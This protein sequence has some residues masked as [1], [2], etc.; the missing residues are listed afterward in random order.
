MVKR[1][2]IVW[3]TPYFLICVA[4][5]MTNMGY[6]RKEIEESLHQ[7][8]YDDI[9]ATYLLLGRRTAEVLGNFVMIF[10]NL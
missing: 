3:L 8:K 9:T 10:A 6:S 1:P 4:D 5:I 7:N 2:I